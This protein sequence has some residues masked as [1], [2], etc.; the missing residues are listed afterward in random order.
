MHSWRHGSA[1]PW[2]LTDWMILC[3]FGYCFF[4]KR[5]VNKIWKLFFETFTPEPLQLLLLILQKT[6]SIINVLILFITIWSVQWKQK[7]YGINYKCPEFLNFPIHFLL[8]NLQME[9]FSSFSL[10]NNYFIGI[11]YLNGFLLV[12]STFQN[13]D[14]S[15]TK[16]LNKK[17]LTV[18]YGDTI[19]HVKSFFTIYGDNQFQQDISS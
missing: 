19:E 12:S 5:I 13:N 17:T 7:I 15:A 18:M 10:K 4:S 6:R 16:P 14:M 8:R 2:L 11:I 9:I 3:P 1:G